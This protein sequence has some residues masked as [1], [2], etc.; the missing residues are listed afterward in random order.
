MNG[1]AVIDR[2]KPPESGFAWDAGEFNSGTKATITFAQL[3]GNL[4]L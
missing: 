3:R 4:V 1:A 2:V